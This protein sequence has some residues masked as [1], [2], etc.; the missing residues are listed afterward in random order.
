MNK[1]LYQSRS[2]RIAIGI[3]LYLS[4]VAVGLGSAW[5]VLTKAPWMNATVQTGA[6]KANLRAGSPDADMYTRAS[7]ALNALLALDRDETMYFVA[8]HDDTGKSLRSSCTY[9]VEGIPPKARWWSITAY[10]DDKFLFDAPGGHYS[11][12][13][14]TATLDKNGRFAFT[15]GGKEQP[16]THWLPT[17]GDRGLFLTLRLYNPEKELQAAPTTMA[18]PTITPTGACA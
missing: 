4:A 13:G 5:W 6:W 8:T 12:N 14:S 16:G 11:L 9:R 1:P 7:V 10:A 18:P 2:R 3:A 17:P 15:T